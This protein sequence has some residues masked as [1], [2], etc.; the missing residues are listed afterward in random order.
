LVG[1]LLNEGNTVALFTTIDLVNSTTAAPNG[2]G[3]VSSF[4]SSQPQQQYLG[5]LSENSPLPFSIPLDINR[6]APAG[7]FPVNLRVTYSDNLRNVHNLV[8]EETVE[9]EPLPSQSANNGGGQ[10][11]NF[12]NLLL[13]AVMDIPTMT[14]TIAISAIAVWI[15]LIRR[16]RKRKKAFSKKSIDNLENEGIDLF[17]SDG[18]H[19][20]QKK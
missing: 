15:L 7:T 11:V 10:N 6:N 9:Y 20:D 13:V 4:L 14:A 5:D 17:L 1:N 3:S 8:L 18:T 2:Q 16:R 19:S 12:I